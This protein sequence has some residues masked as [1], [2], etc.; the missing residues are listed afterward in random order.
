VFREGFAVA[1]VG[2]ADG[3]VDYGYIKRDGTW[4]VR[5]HGEGGYFPAEVMGFHEGAGVLPEYRDGDWSLQ[6]RPGGRAAAVRRNLR[7][8]TRVREWARPHAEIA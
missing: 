4:L 1:S 2:H 8:G 5:R 7:G 3:T 6:L